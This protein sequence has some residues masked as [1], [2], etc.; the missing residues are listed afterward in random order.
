M[1][2]QRPRIA[3]LC[4]LA[5][6]ACT[7]ISGPP[8]DFSRMPR[9]VRLGQT[10]VALGP[11]EQDVSREE[12]TAAVQRLVER[13]PMCF[14]W[15]GVWLQDIGRRDVF[16]LRFDL[17]ERDWGAETARNGRARMEEFVE[18]GFLVGEEAVDIGP[19]AVRY[20]LT[21]RGAAYMRGSPYGGERPQFCAPAERQVVA[22]TDLQWGQFSCG[23][24]RVRFSHS[25]EAWPQWART[26]ETQQRVAETWGAPREVGV[27]QVTLG[28]EW[29][30]STEVPA[31]MQ[32][33]GAL[34]SNCAEGGR[35]TGANDLELQAGQPPVPAN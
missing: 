1:L 27:G 23:N 14:P 11:V 16:L 4:A 19:G 2:T 15:P 5:V 29:H 21:A 8:T 17:M 30:R 13:A 32:M 25:S 12:V 33:N 3:A 18:Q 34:R 35:L 22:L 28:R 20:T 31:D 6:G 7:A 26:R 10:Q 9:E 24:L